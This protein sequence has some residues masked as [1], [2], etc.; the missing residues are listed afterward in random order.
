[1]GDTSTDQGQSHSYVLVSSQIHR[2]G[3]GIHL[4]RA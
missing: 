4:R 3:C 1:M 2:S